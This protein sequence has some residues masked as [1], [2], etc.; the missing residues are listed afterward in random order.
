MFCNN[1]YLQ[2][3]L[4]HYIIQECLPKASFF[5]LSLYFRTSWIHNVQKIYR[6]RSKLVS[7]L[8]TVTVF[9]LDK[10]VGL[11]HNLYITTP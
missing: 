7:L 10:Y 6:S 9:G 8:L 4:N 2:F 5:S 3:D 11:L 1:K